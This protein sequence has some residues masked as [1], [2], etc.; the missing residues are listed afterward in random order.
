MDAKGN[1]RELHLDKAL[2]V[3]DLHFALDPVPA[4][5]APCAR[6]L[7]TTYFTLDLLKV[8]GEAAVPAVQDFGILTA[9]DAVEL[10]WQGGSRHLAAGETVL[11]PASA[12]EMT[13][14]GQ[15]RVALSMPAGK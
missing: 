4:P 9:L 14:K 12:P 11:V 15:G 1:K 5:D 3:T 10:A 2:D 6:V 7:D 8:D 13:V